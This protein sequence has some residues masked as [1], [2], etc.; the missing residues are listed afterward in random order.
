MQQSEL[1]V[2][3]ARATGESPRTIARRGFSLVLP[4]QPVDPEGDASHIPNCL[5][6]EAT[7]TPLP[8]PFAAALAACAD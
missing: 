1:N 5:D 6:W 4:G 8:Y 7:P 3:V 2:A